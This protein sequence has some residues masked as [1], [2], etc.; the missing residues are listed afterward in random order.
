M[1]KQTT[2]INVKDLNAQLKEHAKENPVFAAVCHV[3]AVRERARHQVTVATLRNTLA[4]EGFNYKTE[5]LIDVLK[6]MAS[7]GLGQLRK[8]GHKIV[9]LEEIRYS[10]QSIGK[11]AISDM[12]KLDEFKQPRRFYQLP[13]NPPKAVEKAPVKE[14][15]YPVALTTKINGKIVEVPLPSNWTSE[16]FI[17]FFA[18]IFG[19]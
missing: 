3:F 16:Q 19:K 10:L 12:N 6:F 5:D 9:A 1:E 7:I 17:E 15:P 2:R 11:T 13:P 8:S 14:G 18:S 4:K